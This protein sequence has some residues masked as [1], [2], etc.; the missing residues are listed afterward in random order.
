MVGVN[1][2]GWR[3]ARRRALPRSALFGIRTPRTLSSSQA[4]ADSQA[5]GWSVR[6]VLVP[7]Y[8]VAAVLA[9]MAWRQG[10]LPKVVVPLVLTVAGI[11]VVV[12]T[13]CVVRAQHAAA[14]ADPRR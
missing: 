3:A 1:L 5:A 10:H 6:L 9:G 12:S 2:V 7:V 13:V 11:D 4:W 14:A 8:A